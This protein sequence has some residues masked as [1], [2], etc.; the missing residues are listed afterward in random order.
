MAIGFL[1]FIWTV[2]TFGGAVTPFALTPALVIA[3]VGMG[4]VV[5]SVYP[6]ILAEVPLKHAG[7]ASGVVNAVG[8]IGGA[9]GVAVVG[10]IFFGLIGS[11][12]TVSVDSVRT[13][14]TAD[15]SAAGIPAFAQPNI[16]AS[17][18]AC[19]HDRATAKD[20]SAVPES[21]TKA[22]E[23]QAVFAATQPA[24]AEAVGLAIAKHAKDANQRN[25]TTAIERTLFWEVGALIVIFF[26]TFFLPRRPRAEADL[27]A[28]GVAVA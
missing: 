21:C 11:Q 27:A 6:F 22:Q 3:G 17:F 28:A 24:M 23:A 8:Q 25:F 13:E 20:F 19:F 18:E 2:H 16:I 26:L 9:I 4:F 5:A 12:S 10:V 15:L 1:L 14:L 7:S